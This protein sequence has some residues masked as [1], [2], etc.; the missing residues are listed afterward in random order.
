VYEAGDA[1]RKITPLTE[2]CVRTSRTGFLPK[3]PL[4]PEV[5]VPGVDESSRATGDRVKGKE[6]VGFA[7]V[8]SLPP[9]NLNMPVLLGFWCDEADVEVGK[10]VGIESSLE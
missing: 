6:I 8:F 3:I 4:G 2:S 7:F 5:G 10:E 9:P 1:S